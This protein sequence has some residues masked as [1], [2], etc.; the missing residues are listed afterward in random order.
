VI[1][2]LINIFYRSIQVTTIKN[3]NTNSTKLQI[4]MKLY[5]HILLPQAPPASLC[6]CLR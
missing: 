1:K 5:C 3:N 6:L 2:K 4:I